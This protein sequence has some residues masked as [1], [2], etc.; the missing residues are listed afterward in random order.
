MPPD[1]W[2]RPSQARS[3]AFVSNRGYYAGGITLMLAAVALVVRPTLT[4][5]AVAVFAGVTLMVVL[6]AGPLARDIVELPG[7][8]TAHNGR[9]V[10]FVLLALALLAG[11][12]L[13]EVTRRELPSRLRRNL[14]LGAAGAIFCV[15]IAWLVVAGTLDLGQLRPALRVAW[16]FAEPPTVTLPGQLPGVA[17]IVRLSALLQWLPLAGAALA[18]AARWLARGGSPPAGARRGALVVAALAIVVVDLFR[19]NMGFNPAIRIEHAEQPVTGAIRTSSRACRSA[20]PASATRA[21]SSRSAWTWPC[22][23]ASTTRAATTSRWRSATTSCG[24]PRSARPA[25]SCA[26][27]LRAAHAPGPAHA[28]PAERGR[29]DAG[30]GRRA[31]APARAEAGLRGR[32]RARLSQHAGAAAVPGRPPAHGRRR[33]GRARRDHRRRRYA[34]GGR[35]G[36]RA[37][38]HPPG[39]RRR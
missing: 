20:S 36:G 31:A 14:A 7:F 37:A 2:G 26:D 35:D 9:M 17:P 5:V 24:A 16:G 33:G 38:R 27:S 19:A 22:A 18:V 11:W 1:Y 28:E 4:R 21:P 3:H 29:R 8:R 39:R 30:P 15:P 32:R 34:H 12:G 10:I 23:T 25:R 6:G 13:D